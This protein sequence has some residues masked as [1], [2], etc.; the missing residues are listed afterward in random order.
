MSTFS[1]VVVNRDFLFDFPIPS[2]F[3]DR[4]AFLC[5]ALADLVPQVF[6]VVRVGAGFAADEPP[7][8][9]N[10]VFPIDSGDTSPCIPGVVIEIG[11]ALRSLYPAG[12]GSIA[13]TRITAM[14]PEASA[15]H[16][17]D[18]KRQGAAANKRKP[19]A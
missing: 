16:L 5:K 7:T 8:A 11:S 6:P 4:T 10:A 18:Y 1:L 14:I 9:E 19:T 12:D 15:A 17:K 3:M 13:I 2:R